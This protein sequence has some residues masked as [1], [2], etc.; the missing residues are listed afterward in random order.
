ML[1]E[2]LEQGMSTAYR[3]DTAYCQHSSFCLEGAMTNDRVTFLAMNQG[4][5]LA[6]DFDSK[7]AERVA[8]QVD[9]LVNSAGTVLL[10]SQEAAA[11]ACPNIQFTCEVPGLDMVVC[12]SQ[13]CSASSALHAADPCLIMLAAGITSTPDQHD[14]IFEGVIPKQAPLVYVRQV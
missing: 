12:S 5:A 6:P 10:P 1:V 3:C 4:D 14:S 7:L 13:S 2:R 9:V 8:T 11:V